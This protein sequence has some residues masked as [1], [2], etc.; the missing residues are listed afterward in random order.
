MDCI[1]LE[2]AKTQL[3][4][5]FYLPPPQHNWLKYIV[6]VNLVPLLHMQAH[7]QTIIIIIIINL[8]SLSF[9]Q[10]L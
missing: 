2:G 8:D 6:V 3:F 10:I 1:A 4:I 7:Y 5:V 9:Y